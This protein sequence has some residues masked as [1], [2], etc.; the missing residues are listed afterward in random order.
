VKL[1]G[2]REGSQRC[3]G[4]AQPRGQAKFIN[5]REEGLFLFCMS[6][7]R[8]GLSGRLVFLDAQIVFPPLGHHYFL[9]RFLFVFV[10]DVLDCFVLL[11]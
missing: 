2:S 11:L 9:S 8:Q 1:V 10:L 6:V 3:F 4:V 7:L 5:G